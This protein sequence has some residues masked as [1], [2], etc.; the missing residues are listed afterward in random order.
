M[1]DSVVSDSTPCEYA[2][3]SLQRLL[4]YRRRVEAGQ[5]IFNERDKKA[6]AKSLDVWA[7]KL[8]HIRAAKHEDSV[9]DGEGNR[10]ADSRENAVTY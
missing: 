6:V 5:L 2:A 1:D 7:A 4:T 3:G 8:D 9:I 10:R